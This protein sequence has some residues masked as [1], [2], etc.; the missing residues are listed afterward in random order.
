MSKVWV[1]CGAVV[2]TVVAVVLVVVTGVSLQEI[3]SLF[4]AVLC[5]LWLVLLL[6]VPWNL[7]FQA[8]A[9]IH[10]IRTSRARGI[11]V[12]P[13]REPEAR[14]IAV[15]MRWFAIGAHLVS[16]GIVALITAVSGGAIGYYLAGLYLVSTFFRP[17]GAY[18][19]Y[20]RDRMTSMLRDVKHPRDDLIETLHRLETLKSDVEVLNDESAEQAQRLTH[21]EQTLAVADTRATDRDRA[22]NAKVDA[23]ARQFEHSLTRLTDNQ[24][25]IAGLKAFLR[26]VREEPAGGPE[27]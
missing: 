4:L 18:F 26:L 13:E 6:T 21:L 14:R 16:A 11:D 20:L 24:E 10:E 27:L 1:L 8:Q 9:L 2:V 7:S 17:A 23:H 5:L 25:V 12:P 15:R 22:L 19:A 3:L